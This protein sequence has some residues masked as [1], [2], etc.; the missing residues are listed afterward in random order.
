MENQVPKLG[1]KE[2]KI[3]PGTSPNSKE[4]FG[5]S[6]G[7]FPTQKILGGCLIKGTQRKLEIKPEIA[8]VSKA[9]RIRK[10]PNGKA[11]WKP[12]K[13]GK[14]EPIRNLSAPSLK[15]GGQVN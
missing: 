9:G 14:K 6:Q 7:K 12:R 8:K 2:F 5:A 4:P 10:E 15:K 11:K 3:S 13:G 1:G